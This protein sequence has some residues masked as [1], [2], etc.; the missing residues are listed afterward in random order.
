MVIMRRLNYSVLLLRPSLVSFIVCSS[1]AAAIMIVSNW[2]S[3]LTQV[4]FYDYFFGNEGLVTAL[5][6]SRGSGPVIGQALASKTMQHTMLIALGAALAGVALYVLVR[7]LIRLIGSVSMTVN[8]MRAVDTPAKR[9][10]EHEMVRRL[11]VRLLV[12]LVWTL[13]TFVFIKVVLPFCIL[14]SEVGLDQTSRPTM[15]MAYL[16]FAFAL[17]FVS[18]HLHVIA[19][20]LLLL[21]VRVFGSPD[22]GY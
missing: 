17:L 16:L 22:V 8:E 3:V 20:R 2:S 19:M 18:L 21:K 4:P 7:A 13:Y 15:A 5:Q 9:A 12:L 14:A 1:C 11:G 6:S 10:I